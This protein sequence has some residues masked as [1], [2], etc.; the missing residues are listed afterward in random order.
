MV[1]PHGLF[2]KN[3]N[4]NQ[5]DLTVLPTPS[6][7][8]FGSNWQPNGTCYRRIL[9]KEVHIHAS[10]RG[11]GTAD[12]SLLMS[13]MG[14]AADFTGPITNMENKT[15]GYWR[16]LKSTQEVRIY[17]VTSNNIM[18]DIFYYRAI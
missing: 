5:Q 9:G 1:K 18:M 14:S 2:N 12:G 6:G 4:A 13:G 11:G 7:G 10:L 15:C 3:L 17:N 16:L 8:D